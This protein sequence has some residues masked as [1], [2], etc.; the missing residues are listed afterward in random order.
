MDKTL[1]IRRAIPVGF[2]GASGEIERKA[3]VAI[4]REKKKEEDKYAGLTPK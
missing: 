2:E 4:Q 3:T 1:T